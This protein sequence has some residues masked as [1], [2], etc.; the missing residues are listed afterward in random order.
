M[1]RYFGLNITLPLMEA[2]PE[3]E[4]GKPKVWRK[5]LKPSPRGEGAE[6]SEADEG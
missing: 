3:R 5:G 6:Q 1:S 2:V 4:G